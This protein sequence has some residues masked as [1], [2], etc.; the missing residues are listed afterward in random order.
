M[1]ET[2]VEELGDAAVGTAADMQDMSSSVSEAFTEMY[3]NV[4]ETVSK[5]IDLFSE[6]NGQA[7]LT[8]QELLANMQSQVD[9]ISQ[10]ADNLEALAERGIDQ[11]LLKH[12]SDMGP[13]GAAY[14]S[15]FVSMTDEELQKAG[16][17]Y[18]EAMSLPDEAASQI[19]ESWEIAGENAGQ[20][21]IDGIESKKE[22][23]T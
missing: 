6:F 1:A 7:E 14:V 3:D 22:E 2:S 10:W 20:G 9:G 4:A 19:A 11:G 18:T 8:S 12:L 13:E 16:E 23:A 21:Y 5:Q 15:T 17:L